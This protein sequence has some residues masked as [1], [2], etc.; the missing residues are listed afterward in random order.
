M[1]RNALQMSRPPYKDT[2][3]CVP[4]VGHPLGK[5]ILPSMGW[6][7]AS[8][9][10]RQSLQGS[11]AGWPFCLSDV[12]CSE[13]ALRAG[14]AGFGAPLEWQQCQQPGALLQL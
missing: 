9:M 4:A 7:G 2:G 8:S 5:G 1:G 14:P 11:E 10:A 13:K 6:L 3:C 12:G